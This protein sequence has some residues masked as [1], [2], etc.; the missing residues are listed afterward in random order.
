MP[1]K[2]ELEVRELKT[3]ESNAKRGRWFFVA[4]FD[5][6][7]YQPLSN[8]EGKPEYAPGDQVS[9]LVDMD[10]LS[11]LGNIKG[12]AMALVEGSTEDDIDEAVMESL[13]ATEQPGRGLRVFANAFMVKTRSDNDFTKVTWSSGPDG[14]EAKK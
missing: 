7:T 6:V 4:E 14:D 2:Y 12:F 10:Q 8:A 11:A 13:V 3:F 9:W 1:G 5:V